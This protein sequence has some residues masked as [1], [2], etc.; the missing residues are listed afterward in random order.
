MLATL[1]NWK[2][3]T[4]TNSLNFCPEYKLVTKNYG[5]GETLSKTL[6]DMSIFVGVQTIT[7]AK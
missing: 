7:I 3:T 4:K 1:T 2:G 6:S 5:T